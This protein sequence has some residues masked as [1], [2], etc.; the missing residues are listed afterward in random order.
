MAGKESARGPTSDTVR[1]NITAVR[2]AR[3]LNYTQVSEQLA[4]LGWT[5]S[6]VGVRRIESGER[7]VDVDDLVAFA[8]ALG[9]SPAS[10]LMPN[11]ATVVAKDVVPI[12]GWKKPITATLVWRWLT[13]VEPLIKG[14]VGTFIDLALPS[15]ERDERL[16]PII[17]PGE[18]R[19]DG[20]D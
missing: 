11:L 10:L 16:T 17:F 7:R 8:V 4:H 20:N 14:T 1:T 18:S 19:A 13:A 2:E 9:V 3:N 15:W 6:A 5:I 12:T